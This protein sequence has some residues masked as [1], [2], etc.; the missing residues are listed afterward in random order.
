MPVTHWQ[1]V[2]VVA[3]LCVVAGSCATIAMLREAGAPAFLE[4]QGV[5]GSASRPT[6]RSFLPSAG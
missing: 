1:S 4:R 3:P 6:E 5:R 2:S